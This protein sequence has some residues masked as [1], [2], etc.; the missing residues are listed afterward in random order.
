MPMESFSPCLLKSELAIMAIVAYHIF[1][2]F[3]V[4]TLTFVVIEIYDSSDSVEKL[5]HWN[6]IASAH[7]SLNVQ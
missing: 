7:M 1:L 5:Y 3:T 6:P 4:I 2:F